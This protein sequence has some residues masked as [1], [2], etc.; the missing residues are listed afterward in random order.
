MDSSESYTYE[1]L[2]KGKY[3][4][5]LDLLPAEHLESPIQL[6]LRAVLVQSPM[7]SEDAYEALS[8]VWGTGGVGLVYC[9]GKGIGITANCLTALRYLRLQRKVRTLWVDAIC[10]NQGGPIEEKNHQVALMSDVYTGASK[11]LM[12][13]GDKRGRG[14]LLFRLR[15]R[16]SWWRGPLPRAFDRRMYQVSVIFPRGWS[17]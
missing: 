9:G 5:V 13:L 7:A 6:E 15:E 3:I 10:I 16:R 17:V 8:Y 1:P 11:V 2:P 4:R 14:W 12:W